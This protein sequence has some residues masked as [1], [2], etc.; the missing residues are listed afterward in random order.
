VTGPTT[1]E[2]TAAPA[3]VASSEPDPGG[4][5]GSG[6]DRPDLDPAEGEPAVLDPPP[7]RMDRRRADAPWL[8]RHGSSL[9][10]LGRTLGA[11][12]LSRLVVAMGL[13]SV[14]VVNQGLATHHFTGPWPTPPKASLF[15]QAL[16]SW[17]GSWYLLI[18]AHGYF[19]APS[20]FPIAPGSAF[21]FFPGWPLLLRGLS[22]LTGLTPIVVGVAMA[23]VFGAAASVALW[24]LVR[25]LCDDA[26]ADRA[27]VLWVFFPGAVVLSMVYSEALAILLCAVCLLALLKGQWLVAGCAAGVATGVHPEALVLVACCL[28]AAGVAVWRDR[29]WWSLLAPVLSLAGVAAYFLYLWNATGDL[30]RWYHVERDQWGGTGFYHDTVFVLRQS[31]THPH[32]L[33]AVVP[34]LGLVFAL[35]ALYL[36]VRWRPP[37]IIWIYTVGIL[38]SAFDSNMVGARP[39][40]L[41]T[42]FPLIVAVARRVRPAAFGMVAAASGFLLAT[43]TFLLFSLVLVA[44]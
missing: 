17:D 44:P 38:L 31:V 3:S 42:A 37:V 39:R 33:E 25:H 13:G 12:T 5:G 10:T 43:M 14:L 28:W 27:V 15:L 11:F 8:R 40:V 26:V 36:M 30:L 9:A 4:V 41:L 23:F 1:D 35:V 21:G 32:D 20:Q 34:A 6:P 18:A 2:G 19:P 22:D 7:S 24:Y 16:G 29:D